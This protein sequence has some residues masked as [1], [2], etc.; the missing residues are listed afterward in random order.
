MYR[1][2]IHLLSALGLLALLTACA[3]DT[4]PTVAREAVDRSMPVR[5][6]VVSRQDLSRR[7]Q[8][9][10]PVQPLRTIELAARTD[11][12]ISEVLVEAGDRVTAGDVLARIDV[13]EQRAELARAEAS[14]H[15]AEANFER[16]QRLRERDY[17]D[18]ASYVTAQS[19]LEVAQTEV[20]LWQT[21]VEFGTITAPI[22]GRVIQRMIEPGAAIGRLSAAFELADLNRLVARVGVSE[23]DVTDIQVGDQVP[24]TIDAL[25]DAPALEGQVRRIFPAAEGTSRLVTVEIALP[26]AYALGVRPG[27]L[28]RAD[29]LVDYKQGVLAVPAGS[30]GMGE[31]NYVMVIDERNELV[32]R[33]VTSGVIRGGWREIKGGLEPGDRIVSSNPLELAEGDQ[34]RVVD[35]LESGA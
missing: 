33:A 28:A 12:I 22:D 32:R 30:V 23:L 6:Y 3:E 9:S 14:L 21:R 2:S 4:A 15:E 20:R 7:I 19:L 35:T 11:G 24:I 13:R 16:L 18:E 1:Q 25:G 8:L 26:G 17:I 31:P 5:A 29:L 10:S 34:V 27:F